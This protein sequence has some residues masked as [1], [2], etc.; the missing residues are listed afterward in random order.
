[1]SELGKLVRSYTAEACAYVEAIPVGTAER[2]YA[3]DVLAWRI[4]GTEMPRPVVEYELG[5]RVAEVIR[6]AIDERLPKRDQA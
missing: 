4:V 2:I 1:M 6:E 3:Q 5:P